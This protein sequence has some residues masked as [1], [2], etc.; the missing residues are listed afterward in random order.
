MSTLEKKLKAENLSG[1][2]KQT[3]C[4]QLE[5]LLGKLDKISAGGFRIIK[6]E[7]CTQDFVDVSDSRSYYQDLI[8]LYRYRKDC[9][10]QTCLVSS[11]S[12]SKNDPNQNVIDNNKDASNAKEVVEVS[13][14]NSAAN[15]T[16]KEL[17]VAMSCSSRQREVEKLNLSTG[18]L[19]NKQS[20]S[21]ETGKFNKINEVEVM[22]LRPPEQK[23]EEELRLP[24]QEQEL[25]NKKK[26]AEAD[27]EQKH[28]KLEL[29]K[30]S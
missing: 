16:R 21:R 5:D 17:I 14:Q 23:Q 8:R 3:L 25:E 24:Q 15:R 4:N 2:E 18:C 28:L 26:R 13:S 27:E 6:P 1:S 12:S 11:T 19:S 9:G 30:R 20:K 29:T 10:N 22:K 7:D